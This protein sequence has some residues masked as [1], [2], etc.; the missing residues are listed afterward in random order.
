MKEFFEYVQACLAIRKRFA[1]L[2]LPMMLRLFIWYKA[3]GLLV[4]RIACRVEQEFWY[5]QCKPP[6][7][8]STLLK[9]SR[10]I[11]G[12]CMATQLPCISPLFY[13]CAVF[14]L[15]ADP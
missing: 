11:T 4:H 12:K 5:S 15:T 13:G 1:K 9:N 6:N 7:R 14:S 2:I 3:I 10:R 8:S